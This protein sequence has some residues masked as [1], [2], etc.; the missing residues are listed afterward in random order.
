[1]AMVIVEGRRPDRLE[2]SSDRTLRMMFEDRKTVFVDLLGWDLP[3]LD[4]RFEVD[5]FDDEDAVYVIVADP[6]GD[7][8]G[9]AR[10]IRTDRPHILDSMF[11]GLCAAAPPSGPRIFEITRFCLSPRRSAAAR[12]RTR[13]RLVT[14]L[15]RYALDAGIRT[16]TGVAELSWLQQILAFGWDCRPLGPPIR[17]ECGLLGALAIEIDGKTP[18]LLAANGLWDC[19]DAAVQSIPRAA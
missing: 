5:G 15:A 13:N 19:G 16:F 2:S 9:S 11:P 18:A 1:M 7:H 3:V 14:G 8:L 17:F 4:G 6:D 10:L 12:R